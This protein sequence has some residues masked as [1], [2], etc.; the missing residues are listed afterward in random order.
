MK[1]ERTAHGWTL[2]EFA[3]QTGVDFTTLSRI[4]NGKRPPN[5]GVADACDRVFP[6][7]RGW[8]REYYEE[9]KSWVPASFRSWAEYEDKAT[10]LRVWSPG[11][12]HGLVQ[13]EDYARELLKTASGATPEIVASR[14]ASRMERQR[15]VLL[16]EDPPSVWFVVD[17]LS[18]YRE[19]GSP[20]VMAGQMTHLLEVAAMPNVVVQILPAVAHPATQSG[21]MVADNAAY[22]EH[23]GAGFTYTEPQMV[24][25]LLRMFT[26]IH[27]ESY[28]AS[29]SLRMT[30]EVGEIWA[31]GASPLT[32]ART[33]ETA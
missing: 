26:T 19:V 33:A 12:L 7:R 16:K 9:S 21:F 20:E 27:S 1:K 3:D 17:A 2:K 29:E 13:T 25:S 24:S 11:V 22:A 14:L 5:E 30:K 18:L 15:R 10:S 4:E 23:V 32:V 6:A 28:R 8:F 31:T